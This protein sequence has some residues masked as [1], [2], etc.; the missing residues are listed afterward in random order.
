MAHL[1][2]RVAAFASA[3]AAAPA[4][5]APHTEPL[6]GAFALAH[7][8]E[9]RYV[10]PVDGSVSDRQGLRF[11][12]QDGSR[13]V[14]RLSGTGSVGA[15][16]RVYIEKLELD[17]ARQAAATADALRELVGLA[18]AGLV[19]LATVLGRAAPTVIT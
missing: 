16:V 3:S 11:V 14:Y 17:A 15:T 9:F 5:A 4:G 7:C 13:V 12:M 1:R 6:G 10:D 19:D 18:T 8:D 2:Q